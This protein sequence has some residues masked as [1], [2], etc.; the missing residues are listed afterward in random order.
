MKK[1]L[2]LAFSI[3]FYAS[4]ANGQSV[5]DLFTKSA[6][7]IYWLGIDFSHVKL[8]GEFSQFSEWGEAGAEAIKN[9][10]F[11]AWNELIIK[12]YTKYDIGTMIRKEDVNLKINTITEVNE[13]AITEGMI[14]VSDPNYTEADIRSWVAN[15]PYDVQEGLGI[16]FIAESLNK[17]RDYGKYHVVVINLATKE[18]LLHEVLKG[19]SGGIG[20]RNY[21]ARSYCEVMN[22]IRDYRY[23][24]WKKK[25]GK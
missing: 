7:P 24:D 20:L 21:W 16:L 2:F 19:R 10:Y 12:E 14:D 18:V 8:I 17:L 23:R 5:K 9:K 3:L 6:T 13:N 15:Y 1:V 4:N 11:P 25:Y 22:E